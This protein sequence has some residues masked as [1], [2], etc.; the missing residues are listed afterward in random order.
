MSSIAAM[1]RQPSG[2]SLPPNPI[3]IPRHA[4]KRK[5]EAVIVVQLRGNEANI[6]KIV[7]QIGRE[8]ETEGAKL[9]QID[10]LGRK[11]FA[12]APRHMDEGYY[13]NYHFEAEPQ[14]VHNVRSK[15]KL[16]PDVCMQHYQRA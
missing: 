5:Y 8:I 7:S 2:T 11:K 3:P 10:Q 6:D 4:M 14:H 9:Q 16:N 13:V 15:L 12:Y 1:N